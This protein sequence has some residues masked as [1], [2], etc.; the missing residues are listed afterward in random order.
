MS[1]VL[2]SQESLHPQPEVGVVVVRPAP[3]DDLLQL[4]PADLVLH[5][6]HSHR[7]AVAGGVE[8]EGEQED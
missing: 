7:L 4:L 2:L 3:T 6:P 5:Q 8:G 1:G